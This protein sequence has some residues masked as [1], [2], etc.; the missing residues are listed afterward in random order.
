MGPST[1]T[2]I[3]SAMLNVG[4]SSMEHFLESSGVIDDNTNNNNVDDNG[5]VR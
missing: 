3:S 1:H 2:R 5:S 4:E